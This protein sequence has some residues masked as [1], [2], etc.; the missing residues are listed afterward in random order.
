MKKWFSCLFSLITPT[1]I[2]YTV[3]PPIRKTRHFQAVRCG[4]MSRNDRNHFF[5]S[6]IHLL[7]ASVQILD[8]PVVLWYPSETFSNWQ[9][10]R[11]SLRWAANSVGEGRSYFL[12]LRLC[13]PFYFYK[14]SPVFLPFSFDAVIFDQ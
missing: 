14:K 10:M 6:S 1:I 8:D 5:P 4:A 13:F 7:D 9:N 2:G 12:I 3:A 11:K